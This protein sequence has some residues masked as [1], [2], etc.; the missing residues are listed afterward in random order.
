MLIHMEDYISKHPLFE[1]WKTLR[2]RKVLCPEWHEN[3]RAFHV[4]I[5]D[6]PEGSKK[7]SRHDDSKPYGPGNAFWSRTPTREETLAYHKAYN[8]NYPLKRRNKHL[9][10]KFGITEDDYLSMFAAQNG[11]CAICGREENASHKA[12]KN[13]EKRRMAVDHCHGSKKVRDLLCTNCNTALGALDD[14]VDRMRKCID[15]VLAWRERHKDD[16]A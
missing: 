9:K 7:L 12:R 3:F 4:G 2:A 6:R 14:D 1:R 5:G 11:L 8:S 15:Y 10:D 16:A 13:G